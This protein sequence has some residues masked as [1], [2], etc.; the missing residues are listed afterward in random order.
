M[1]PSSCDHNAVH[2]INN[3]A[4]FPAFAEVT[5]TNLDDSSKGYYQHLYRHLGNR[6]RKQC[7]IT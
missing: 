2:N 1:T 5:A 6:F 7:D 3:M 4:L